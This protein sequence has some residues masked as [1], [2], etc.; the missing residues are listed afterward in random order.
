[1]SVP[2]YSLYE[3]SY[4]CMHIII[5]ILVIR[6]MHLI[7]TAAVRKHTM[8]QKSMHTR[9]YELVVCIPNSD[10]HIMLKTKRQP[11]KTINHEDSSACN[12]RIS[13]GPYGQIIFVF[14]H[15]ARPIVSQASPSAGIRP[16]CKKSSP[17]GVIP[18]KHP[19]ARE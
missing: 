7:H 14:S 15:S 17:L 8:K 10:S 3:R 2:E 13:Y 11:S 9:D 18:G 12:R 16:N 5:C 4:C 6:A 1:M 19:A